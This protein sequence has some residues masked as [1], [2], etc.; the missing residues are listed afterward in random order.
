MSVPD[1]A[2]L[3]TAR[4]W[5]RDRIEEGER[6]PCCS[7]FAKVY[8][9]KIHATMARDLIMLYRKFQTASWFHLSEH[10]GHPGD[11]AKLRY[12]N[13][14]VEQPTLRPDGGRAGWWLITAA[15][16]V[17][18][19][20]SGTVPLYAHI[21]DG[22]LLRLSGPDVTIRDALGTRFDY[23]ELMGRES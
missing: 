23:A 22:R 5:L 4:Q 14:V 12:W 18:V 6:C 2:S 11:F 10:V 19:G 3:A 16:A 20:G 9:R 8:R 15:G 13:L 21:Y 1:H 17:W 7:Q